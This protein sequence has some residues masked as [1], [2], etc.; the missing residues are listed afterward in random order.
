MAFDKLAH[1]TGHVSGLFERSAGRQIG[2]DPHYSFIEVGQ[3]LRA[4]TRSE[5][6]RSADD[7]NGAQRNESRPAEQAPEYRLIPVSQPCQQRVLPRGAFRCLQRTRFARP[8]GSP[9]TAVS[10]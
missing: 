8:R 6:E 5:V 7:H 2:A 3:E 9:W 1:L 10:Y 4:E